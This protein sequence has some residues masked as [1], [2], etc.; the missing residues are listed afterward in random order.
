MSWD[1][2]LEQAR[3]YNRRL[4]RTRALMV[5]FFILCGFSGVAF[6]M[7]GQF[8]TVIWVAIAAMMAGAY[9]SRLPR[10]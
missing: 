7:A 1:G 3:R 4:R 2:Y 5:V 8:W 6:A 9:Y 10:A